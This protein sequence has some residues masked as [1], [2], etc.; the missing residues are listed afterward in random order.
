[1]R[2]STGL[3]VFVGILALVSG[4]DVSRVERPFMGDFIMPEPP[5]LADTFEARVSVVV[6]EANGQLTTAHGIWAVDHAA[7][8]VVKRYELESGNSESAAIITTITRLDLQSEFTIAQ[9]G[10]CSVSASSLR[11]HHS[12]KWLALAQ[13][14]GK[15][16]TDLGK[17]DL[18]TFSAGPSTMALAYD[19]STQR[20]IYF[21]VTAHDMVMYEF[22]EWKVT[23]PNTAYF[24]VPQECPPSIISTRKAGNGSEPNPGNC[25]L[26]NCDQGVSNCIAGRHFLSLFCNCFAAAN[27]YYGCVY[28]KFCGHD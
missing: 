26:P 11:M 10:H 28:D 14:E 13:Y 18:W 22:T 7:G 27:Q 19:P 1:M 15:V 25:V 9:D 3:F 24:K 23:S 16:V 21:T 20:P 5:M 17:F 2:S 8:H 12:W 4:I 6:Q